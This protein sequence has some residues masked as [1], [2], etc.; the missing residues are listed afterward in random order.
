MSKGLNMNNYI[1]VFVLF[2]LA[3]C[4]PAL[5]TH[6]ELNYDNRLFS[7]G[8]IVRHH[9]KGS[10]GMIVKVDCKKEHCFYHVRFQG[11]K[12]SSSTCT[13]LIDENTTHQNLYLIEDI[14]SFEIEAV[15]ENTATAFKQQKNRS[16]YEL[17]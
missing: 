1:V 12:L 13:D 14:R 8:D 5:R 9:L 4:G 7:E 11:G 6:A 3:G 2:L 16:Y 15:P 17:N 10:T